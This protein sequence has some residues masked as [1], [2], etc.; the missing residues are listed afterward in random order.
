MTF[1]E[2]LSADSKQKRQTGK[3]LP[4]FLLLLIAKHKGH[5]GA[6]MAEL[7]EL[8]PDWTID[9]G[10]IYRVLRD[11]EEHKLLLSTWD[12]PD[13]GAPRRVYT[14]TDAGRH[15]LNQWHEDILARKRGLDLFVDMYHEWESQNPGIDA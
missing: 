14:L 2:S 15:E 3:H 5:G 6:L 8:L 4:A 1:T 11:M 9:S 10:G 13:G 12:T 7:S